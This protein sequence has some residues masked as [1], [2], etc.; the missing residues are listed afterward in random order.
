MEIV[1]DTNEF[2]AVI[3]L[4]TVIWIYEQVKEKKITMIVLKN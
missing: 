3:M 1:N 4:C 2:Q